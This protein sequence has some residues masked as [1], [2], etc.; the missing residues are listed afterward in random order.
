[1]GLSRLD[2][3][4]KNN[5]GVILYVSPN[6]RDATDSIENQG[7][8]LTRPFKTIQRAL[9]EA[10]RFSYQAGKDNDRFG[11]TTVMLYPGQHFIDN[12]PG[13]IP[14]NTN[15]FKDRAGQDLTESLQLDTTSNFDLNS[16]DNILHKF[17][18][19]FGGVIVPRGTSIVGY[20]LRK[21]AIRPLYV[22]SSTNANIERTALFR[23][24]GATYIWQF[25]IF[26]GNPNGLVYGDYASNQFVPNYSHHKLTSFEYADGVN[27]VNIKDT[28]LT[29]STDRTDLDMYY[30]K[31]GL[32]Y[33]PASGRAISPDYPP[34][35]QVDIQPKIDEYRIVGSTGAEVGI[36]SIKAGDGSTPT[37]TVTVSL[38]GDLAGLDVDTPIR[39]E[40]VGATGY[41]GQFVIQEVINSREVKYQ[42][43]SAPS[44]PLPS[45]TSASLNISVDTVTSASPY[46]YNVSL[47]SVYG[48]SG[49]HADGSKA[50]GF[51]SM[52]LAQFTGVGLQKDNKAFVKFNKMTGQYEDD[53]VAGNENLHTDSS[54][55]FK[56]EYENYHIKC[57]NNAIIQ[58]V[59]VFAVGYARQFWADSGG[60]QS[61]T[62]SNSNFGQRSLNAKGYRDTSYHQD[63]VGNISHTIPPKFVNPLYDEIQLEYTPIDVT[64][65]VGVGSTGHLYLFGETNSDKIPASFIQGFCIGSKKD[66]TLNANLS[67]SGVT[68]Q[69]SATVVMP[70]TQQDANKEISEKVSVVGRTLVGVNSITN[71]VLT[72]MRDHQFINGES[73][74]LFANTGQLPDGLDNTQIYNVIT[75]GS[76]ISGSDQIKIAANLNDAVNDSNL[77]FN[78]NGGLIEVRSRVIDKQAGDIGH[79]IQYDTDNA[80]WYVNVSTAST[81]NNLYD[82]IASA[83][84]SGLG[85]ATPRTFISRVQDTRATVDK[86]YRVRYVV[87]KE[88]AN[89]RPPIDGF[90]IQRSEA[91]GIS[92]SAVQKYFANS[93]ATLS[94]S[95]EIREFNFISNATWL[96]GTATISTELAHDLQVDS[97]VDLKNIKST[98]NTTG[99]GITGYNGRYSVV[100]VSS[101]KEFTVG[102]T[103]DPGTFTSNTS[104]RDTGLPRY[105]SKDLAT[106]FSIY[107]SKTYNEFIKNEQDGVYHL[108]LLTHSNKP[109]VAPFTN[110]SFQQPINNFYPQFD[111]DNPESDPKS[112]VSFAVAS[113]VGKV[114]VDDPEHSETRESL[115]KG[116]ASFGIGIG[117]TDISSSSTTRHKIFFK[118]E[119][120]LNPVQTVNITDPGSNYGTGAVGTQY[121]YNAKLVS[122][123]SSTCGLYA[124]AKVTVGTGGTISAIEVMDGGSSYAVGNELRVVGITTTSGHTPATV[125]VNSIYNNIDSLL[126]VAGVQ[127]KAFDGYNTNYRIV[128]ITTGDAWEVDLES[129]TPIPA[130]ALNPTGL[131]A[132]FTQFAKGY[133][134]DQAIKI[135][136]LDYTPS[137]GI[138]TVTTTTAHGYRSGNGIEIAGAS[139]SIYN[140]KIAIQQVVGLTTFVASIGVGTTAPAVGTNAYA[141]TDILNFRANDGSITDDNENIAGRLIAPFAGVR[142]TL[143]AAITS[144]TDENI[145]IANANN[146]NFLIGTYIICDDELMRIKE[147][148]Q[149]GT[150]LKVFRGVLGTRRQVHVN[151]A[152][153]RTADAFPVGLRRNSIIRAS[154]HTFEYVGFGPGNYSTSLPNRQNR[155]LSSTEK[156]LA[157]SFREDSGIVVFTGMDDSGEFYI[158]NKKVSSATGREEVI[159]APVP[160]VKGQDRLQDDVSVG[161]DVLTPLEV[162]VT[163]SLKV[164]GGPDN[165]QLSEFDGP[166]N[167]NEK[168][169][170]TSD[171]GLE[172]NSL[173]IQGDQTVS[174]RHTIGANQPTTAGTVGDIVFNAN[175][176]NGGV[177]GWVYTSTNEWKTFGQI[178]S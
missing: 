176:A 75:S 91:L 114:V 131:G 54:A 10:S 128:G 42:V 94:D 83:G 21:T 116:L 134:N 33:G 111:R 41:D 155:I 150:A 24:T 82:R 58:L 6:D 25:T 137:S 144:L 103:T 133:A 67:V 80:Q 71:N 165:T 149:P 126:S 22:P 135:A 146:I 44:N 125:N 87:P 69:F 102:I 79:P 30:E 167:F 143:S 8:S 104:I 81:Q 70:N 105:V 20:D 172:V 18:S 74:K 89:G 32:A 163:R 151:G 159:D 98:V 112:T 121:Y 19:V 171:K 4:I 169:V 95:T 62:N 154:G 17:N 174:R 3:F 147:T 156:L 136:S 66:E 173:L 130:A 160:T 28:F 38:N 7:N 164:E 51:K 120:R 14:T 127:P 16:K 65:T 36:T 31:V 157:R 140:K 78:G 158:G 97:S 124:T 29:Y 107:R 64:K 9:L 73:V 166:V 2:N 46:V 84:V 115:D 52:V 27:S 119:H 177:I 59:S 60:D 93:P 85:A 5:R 101:A 100:G 96:A 35:S 63:D 48:M 129:F 110:N 142:S 40:G 132:A 170:S 49:V 99:I 37:T 68:T 178:Q 86:V 53:T 145:N 109:N 113:P 122:I 43:Q 61:V 108:L 23:L 55:N 77:T 76:G 92:T 15:Q 161:F 148:P 138:V 57:S 123:G 13:L 118:G 34:S 139:D 106:T 12:R 47:R 39:I 152:V 26:D 153:I 72:L 162:N 117:V 1:M 56:P 141:V 45:V 168:V 90:V 11:K 175:P 88:A 50:T